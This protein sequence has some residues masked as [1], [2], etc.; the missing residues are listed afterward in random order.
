M[1]KDFSKERKKLKLENGA[2]LS[3]EMMIR[4]DLDEIKRSKEEYER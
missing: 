3:E 1:P 4:F 2:K